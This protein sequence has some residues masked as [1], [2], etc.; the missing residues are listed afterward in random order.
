MGVVKEGDI[1]KYKHTP[2]LIIQRQT[3]EE[4]IMDTCFRICAASLHVK[5]LACISRIGGNLPL[6]DKKMTK[7]W[8]M[9]CQYG[10]IILPPENL[11]D[12]RFLL[13]SIR[14]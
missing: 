7:S 5:D 8:T 13:C 11:P 3:I 1:V 4:I 6:L 12:Q 10:Y 9:G 2:Q 14:A